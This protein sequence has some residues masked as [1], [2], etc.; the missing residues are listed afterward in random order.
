MSA[1][2]RLTV[3]FRFSRFGGLMPE[4]F[5]AEFAFLCFG[6]RPIPQPDDVERMEPQVDIRLDLDDLRVN[7]LERRRTEP[8]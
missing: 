1:G 3:I 6:E 7:A 2:A 5:S 8:S 4:F